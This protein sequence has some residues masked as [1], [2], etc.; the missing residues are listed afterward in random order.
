M[1]EG[2]G[3]VAF[4]VKGFKLNSWISIKP[5][6]VFFYLHKWNR[7]FVNPK[8]T[9]LINFSKMSIFLLDKYLLVFTKDTDLISSYDVWSLE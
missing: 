6:A 2:T 9:I 3:L 4:L 7:F 8:V 5:N 1:T